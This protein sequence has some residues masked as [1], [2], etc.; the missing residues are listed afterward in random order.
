MD[1]LDDVAGHALNHEEYEKERFIALVSRDR[2]EC[3]AN[4]SLDASCEGEESGFTLHACT[5]TCLALQLVGV[6]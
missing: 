1:A 6:N 4:R 2:E 3:A 5:C